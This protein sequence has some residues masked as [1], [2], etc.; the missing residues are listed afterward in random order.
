MNNKVTSREDILKNAKEI[1]AKEGIYKLS[2]R[3]LAKRCNMATGS[4]YNYFPSKDDMILAVVK[5]VWSD[6]F[7]FNLLKGNSFSKAVSLLI[8][9]IDKGRKNYPNFFKIHSLQFSGKYRD[10]GKNFMDIFYARVE[11]GLLNIL[12]NDELVRDDA[13]N[14]KFTKEAYVNFIFNVI[15]SLFIRDLDKKILVSMIEKAIY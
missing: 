14:D 10:E 12:E 3:S 8:D 13:F 11:R 15:L 5:S 4:M 9:S 7:D 2:I 1:I 6:V